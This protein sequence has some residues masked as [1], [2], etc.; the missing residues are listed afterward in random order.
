[1]SSNVWRM[2]P[3]VM[4]MAV[5]LALCAVVS[6]AQGRI[7]RET[8]HSVALEK[9]VAGNSA[10]REVSIYLPPSYDTAPQKRYPVIYLLHGLGA[11]DEMWTRGREGQELTSIQEVMNRGIAAGRFGEMIIVMPNQRTQLAGTPVA[12]SFYANS[13]A[14]GNW[15][16]FTVKELVAHIDG[17]YRTLARASS[18]G[19]MGHSMGGH[20]AFRLGMRHP[21]VFGAV[22]AMAPAVLGWGHDLSINNQAFARALTVTPETVGRQGFFVPAIL[23][24]AQAYSPNPAKPPFFVDLPFEM[25][26][27]RLRPSAAFEKWEQNF[28]LYQVKAYRENLR[29]LRGLR[30]D[31]GY[32]DDFPHIPATA[33]E[34]S[35]RLA[36]LDIPHIFEE[37]N[38]DHVNR[39]WGRDGRLSL[40]AMPWF[41]DVLEK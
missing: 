24:I 40:A 6:A 41:W 9:N 10:D 27:G 11:N 13:A 36:S 12:G 19:L 3:R 14:S 39:L 7:V 32:E 21:E 8:V 15:E 35:R 16:D 29:K 22:Y 38:G 4:V 28:P 37:F 5:A 31:V 25:V 34:L 2:M 33:R 18:R 17:K 1:M 20:G 30:I 23:N 26:E